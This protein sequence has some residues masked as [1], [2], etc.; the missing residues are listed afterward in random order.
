M[1]PVAVAATKI[2]KAGAVDKELQKLKNK[3]EMIA[4]VT[5]NAEKKQV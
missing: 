5:S 4:A 3:L 1:F 2:G